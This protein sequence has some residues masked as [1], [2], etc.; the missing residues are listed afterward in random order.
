MKRRSTYALVALILLCPFARQAGAQ[1]RAQQPSEAAASRAEAERRAELEKKALALLREAVSDAQGL[2]LVENRVRPQAAAAALLWWR[3]E[4]AARALFKAAADELAA[5]GS[6][7][8]PEDQQFYNAAQSQAQM[9][10]ELIQ[11]VAQLDPALALEY[12]R[13]TRMPHADALRAAGYPQDAQEQQLEMGLAAR[14]ASRDPA[15]SLRMARQ[16]LSKGPTTSLVPVLQELW[17]RD[18]ASASKLA[19]EVVA[20][21]RAEEM[22]NN[23][24]ASALAFQ[25]LSLSPPPAP[26]RSEAPSG[27]PA[28]AATEGF[29]VVGVR[30]SPGSPPLMDAQTRAE[31]VE[32]IVAAALSDAPNQQ[33]AYNLQQALQSLLPELEKAAPA[34]AEAIRRRAAALERSFNPQADV[35]R[36]YRRVSEGGTL[37]EI[38]EAATKAPPEV[39]EQLYMQAAWKAANEGDSERAR[40]IVENLS[41]PQQRAQ[42]R[43]SFETQAQQRAAQQGDFAAARA[44]VSRLST[45]EEKVAALM[46]IAEVARWK[47][48]ARAARQLL[49]EARA[50]V[51][52]QASGTQQFMSQLQLAV[53]YAQVDAGESFEMVESAVARLNELLDAAASLEGFGQESFREGELK[54]QNGYVWN[55]LVSQC[56][57]ALTTLA[58]SDFERASADAAAFR[59]ADA[60]VYARMQLAQ[61]LLRSLAQSNQSQ[62]GGLPVQGRGRRLNSLPASGPHRIDE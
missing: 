62:N 15:R 29:A 31:L 34:R 44:A 61:G 53:V 39:R 22:T 25:L 47:G 50:L 45:A 57:T 14:V 48:D 18:P 40:R 43:R 16:S 5:Y 13:A 7:L 6:S 20:R 32:K 27:G 3:D 36:P 35:W 55:D 49:E 2:R 56:A 37:D 21:L 30:A 59:R 60:R 4:Q 41:N 58:P 42:M 33:G 19:A 28:A 17:A 12:L 51:P 46:Q 11:A 26:Q 1:E 8:D 10:N 38:L 24:E 9:R 54:S 52:A 23:Y